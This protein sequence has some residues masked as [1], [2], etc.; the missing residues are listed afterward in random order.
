M[1]LSNILML[2]GEQR[3]LNFEFVLALELLFFLEHRLKKLKY[4]LKSFM[5]LI[6][7]NVYLF[8]AYM[9]YMFNFY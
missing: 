8:F 5:N 2:N 4:S 6:Q 1:L 7:C 3:M 9:T